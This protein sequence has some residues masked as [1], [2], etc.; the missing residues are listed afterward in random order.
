MEEHLEDISMEE[1]LP[2]MPKVIERK[3]ER[4]K[5]GDVT[6]RVMCSPVNLAPEAGSR[7][8]G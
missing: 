7:I 4:G 8:S 3:G 1:H 5:R 2:S 6:P